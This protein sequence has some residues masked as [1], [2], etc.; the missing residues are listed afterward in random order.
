MDAV[1]RGSSQGRSVFAPVGGERGPSPGVKSGQT[2]A[3]DPKRVSDDVKR[4]GTA[5]AAAPAPASLAAQPEP[6]T[7][8]VLV[9]ASGP[10]SET[11]AGFLP[12][13]TLHAV[14]AGS[15]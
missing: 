4:R 8:D 12:L 10:G 14:L 1:N 6:A 5:S 13:N 9:L 2:R 11:L 3:P 15:L 7:E